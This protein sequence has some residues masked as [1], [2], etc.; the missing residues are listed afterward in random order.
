MHVFWIFYFGLIIGRSLNRRMKR[1]NS[2]S[3][4]Y[5]IV[6]TGILA[7]IG[8]LQVSEVCAYDG[9]IAPGLVC[10]EESW[11]DIPSIAYNNGQAENV[12]INSIN[13]ICPFRPSNMNGIT[14]GIYDGDA[15]GSSGHDIACR[16]Y[17]RK[18]DGSVMYTSEKEDTVY[19]TG[20]GTISWNEAE[21][22]NVFG[23]Y[24]PPWGYYARCNLPTPT[25]NFTE[26]SV[27]RYL[28][29]R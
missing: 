3:K 12:Q 26:S 9:Y 4:C 13:M 7:I 6:M 15:S 1:M 23:V 14:I 5:S 8:V 25:E 22:E 18:H 11:D 19:G 10:T 24:P 28:E 27:I 29:I 17:A 21:L 20:I 2:T 16:I